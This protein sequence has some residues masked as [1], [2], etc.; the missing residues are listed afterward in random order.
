M[1]RLNQ[2]K[3]AAFSILAFWSLFRDSYFLY[4]SSKY[5]LLKIFIFQYNKTVACAHFFIEICMRSIYL[6]SAVILR[7]AFL[8]FTQKQSPTRGL[9]KYQSLDKPSLL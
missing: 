5:T 9:S 8:T 2:T 4:F 7:Y 3:P 6:K 1:N